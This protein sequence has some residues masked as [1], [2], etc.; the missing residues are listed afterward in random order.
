M[1]ILLTG[2]NGFL[3]SIVHR[4]LCQY[5]ISTLNTCSGDYVVDLS[6]MT[7]VFRTKFDLVIH[8]AGKAHS[9]PKTENEKQEF[10]NV[11]V[12]GTKNLLIGLSNF[13]VPLYFVFISS[14][15]VYGR[16]FGSDLDENVSLDAV[17]PYGRSKIQAERMVL[18]WCRE[19]QVICTIL[20]L[21]LVVGSNPRGNLAAMINGIQKGYYFNIA[22]GKARKSMVLAEDVAKSIFKVAKI[23]GIYNLT[24]GVHPSFDKLSNQIAIQLFKNRPI[25]VPFRLALILA[26]FG[27]LLG[28]KAPF[29]TYKLKKITSHLT[30][31]DSKAREVFGWSPNPVL[32]G[33]N[34]IKNVK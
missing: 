18:D 23:G 22:G 6:R 20:R 24:D 8:A 32:K 14:V 7:P 5:T 25:N 3:G 10:Y 17:D 13:E 30:F 29:N 1:N 33:L 11:N 4:E 16:N 21:P 9:F 26:K 2:S 15:S 27:D 19:R 12:N 28:N 34:C 31:D